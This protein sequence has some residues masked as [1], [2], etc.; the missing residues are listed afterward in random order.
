MTRQEQMAQLDSM[1]AAYHHNHNRLEC[2][3]HDMRKKAEAITRRDRPKKRQ[4]GRNSATWTGADEAYFLERFF[5]LEDERRIEIV[6][7]SAKMTRQAAAIE[8]LVSKLGLNDPPGLPGV[9]L[10]YPGSGIR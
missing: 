8:A 7:L 5:D 10:V 9:P 2:I 4:Y 1:I 3:A 6:T